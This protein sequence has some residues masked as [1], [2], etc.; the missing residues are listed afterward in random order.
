[1]G[2]TSDGVCNPA[3]QPCNTATSYGAGSNTAGDVDTTRGDGECDRPY[4]LNTIVDLPVRS[5]TWMS[6][7]GCPDPD[8]AYTPGEDTLIA[9]VNFILTVTTGT[10]TA[11][12]ADE[13]GDGCAFAGLGPAGPVVATGVPG[14]GP[15]CVLGQ[16]LQ[17]AGAGPVFSKAP[18]IADTLFRFELPFAISACNPEPATPAQCVL[19]TNN[20]CLD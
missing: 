13:N 2:D 6:P 7:A 14:M 19:D 18:G 9:D 20:G 8:G 3:G 10:A 1:M 5:M 11:G 16:Q 15:C 4:G 12:Y 17:I